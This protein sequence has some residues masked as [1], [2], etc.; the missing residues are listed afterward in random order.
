MKRHTPPA[1]RA[2]RNDA[3]S[4]QQPATERQEPAVTQKGNAPE[5]REDSKKT[6][7]RDETEG[8]DGQH[9][10]LP[11]RRQSAENDGSDKKRNAQTQHPDDAGNIRVGNTPS[12]KNE[13]EIFFQRG[14]F[15]GRAVPPESGQPGTET[16]TEFRQVLTGFTGESQNA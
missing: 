3:D 13:G 14:L 15:R 16:G 7:Q 2:R 11:Y 12:R 9:G 4:L 10:S 8:D 6:W 5:R 1:L